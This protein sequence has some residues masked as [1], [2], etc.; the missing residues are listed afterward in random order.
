MGVKEIEVVVGPGSGLVGAVL[1]VFVRGVRWK[2]V[3]NSKGLTG[4]IDTYTAPG[5]QQWGLMLGYMYSSFSELKR[6]S[7]WVIFEGE[8]KCFDQ[9]TV[10]LK[11]GEDGAWEIISCC[12]PVGSP[13][14]TEPSPWLPG[15]GIPFPQGFLVHWSLL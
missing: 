2:Q 12:G 10:L 4:Y 13:G 5:A 7:S 3:C 6:P 11:G 15:V 9:G 8:N 1:W 14:A